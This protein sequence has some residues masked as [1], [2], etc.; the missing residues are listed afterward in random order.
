MARELK[1]DADVVS[2]ARNVLII[3]VLAIIFTA[4]LG[5]ILML[6]LAPKWLKHSPPEA[7]NVQ[8]VDDDNDSGKGNDIPKNN[9]QR[10]LP[11]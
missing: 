5:A 10:A 6:R 4:P 3:S 8:S 9:A 1:S 2:L 7:S 11:I